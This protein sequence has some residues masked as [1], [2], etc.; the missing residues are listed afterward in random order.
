MS[1]ELWNGIHLTLYNYCVQTEY[2][3]LRSLSTANPRKD[4]ADFHKD[5]PELAG[6]LNIPQLFP[7]EKKFS[8]VFRVSSARLHLWTHYD[9]SVYLQVHVQLLKSKLFYGLS[10]CKSV[11]NYVV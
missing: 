8:S 7:C 4:V 3:Y 9:V 5:Y 11:A 6:D 10:L 1:G 2:C